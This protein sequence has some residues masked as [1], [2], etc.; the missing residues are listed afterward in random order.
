MQRPATP[1]FFLMAS[2]FSR[3]LSYKTPKINHFLGGEVLP[4]DLLKQDTARGCYMLPVGDTPP[5]TTRWYM[6]RTI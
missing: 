5:G 1:I 6:G 3:V 2:L 4:L